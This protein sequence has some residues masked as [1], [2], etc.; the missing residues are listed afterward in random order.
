MFDAQS[1]KQAISEKMIKTFDSLTTQ[2]YN[3]GI[4]TFLSDH[5]HGDQEN[6]CTCCEVLF[7]TDSKKNI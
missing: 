5:V 2:L 1:D 4:K 7:P 3:A 6:L